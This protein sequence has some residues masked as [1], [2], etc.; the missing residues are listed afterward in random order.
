MKGLSDEVIKVMAEIC[1]N[2]MNKN[3]ALRSPEAVRSLVAYKKELRAVSKPKTKLHRKRKVF[4]Q[5]GGF[6]GTLLSVALP[7]IGSLLSGG[8]RR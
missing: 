1:V 7:L 5:K 3:I 8:L 4:E 2:L 6:I